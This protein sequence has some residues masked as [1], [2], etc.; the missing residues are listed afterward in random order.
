MKIK[1]QRIRDIELPAYRHYGD[2]GLDLVNA[3]EDVSIMPGERKLIPSGIRVAIPEG[4]ELQIRSR[5]GLALNS[6]VMVLNS[7]GTVDSGYR[8]E[9]GV[10]L[11]NASKEPV[12]ISRNQ[13]VAQ[14]VLQQVEK[15]SWEETDELPESARKEGGFGSTG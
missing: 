10:I 11:Y 3:S 9:V 13:R 14:A 8:G 15:I 5:S 4:Y 7:P 6:G 12:K 2:S 1:V